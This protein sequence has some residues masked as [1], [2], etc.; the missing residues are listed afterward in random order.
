M[1]KTCC[2]FGCKTGYASQKDTTASVFRFPKEEGERQAWI[3]AIPRKNLVVNN[4]TVI[5]SLHW[6]PGYA[7]VTKN[8][9]ARPKELP[10]VWPDCIPASQIPTPQP[11]PRSTKRTSCSQRNV[12]PDELEE[13]LKRDRV[14]FADMKDELLA[15]TRDLCAPVVVWMDDDDGILNVQ[16]R[17]MCTG[18]PLFLIRISNDQRF[19]NFHMGVKTTNPSLSTN[20]ITALKYWS[21]FEEN[22]QFLNSLEVSNK[23]EVINQ[24]L[25]VM[26]SKAVGKKMYSAE[27]IVRAFH[28][29]ALSRSLYNRLRIDYQLPSVQTLTKITSKVAKLDETAFDSAVFKKKSKQCFP[30]LIRK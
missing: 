15:G 24:H 12:F 18:V 1:V 4:D 28:Y 10:T 17:K 26:G 25:K 8:G 2:V 3:A 11:S 6:P 9:E 14:T 21:A 30:L 27:M 22:V 16:S 19:E 13:F 20:K 7:T 23:K 5:C 29:F